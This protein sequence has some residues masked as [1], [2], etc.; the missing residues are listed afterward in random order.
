MRQ[1]RTQD[2]R[3]FRLAVDQDQYA[4]DDTQTLHLAQLALS[5]RIHHV[6]SHVHN[7]L[8]ERCGQSGMSEKFE[9]IYDSSP[10]G[11]AGSAE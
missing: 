4:F 3:Q 7:L 5:E 1:G 2:T 9:V 10:R 8:Q 11:R 6:S